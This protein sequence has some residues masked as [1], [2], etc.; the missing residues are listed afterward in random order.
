[1]AEPTRTAPSNDDPADP[2]DHGPIHHVP[3]HAARLVAGITFRD[4]LRR[5]GGW[6]ATLL[7][8]M[9]FAL[10]VGALGMT[11]ERVQ[12]RIEQRSFA[13]AIGGDVEGAQEL[14]RQM[15]SPRLIFR[16]AAD[17]ADEVTRSKASS[18]IVFPTGVDR[19][20][21][22]GQQVELQTFYRAS[23]NISVESF[24][25]V[26]T[27]L[28]EV[29]LRRLAQVNGHDVAV[30]GGPAVEVIELPRDERINRIQL[31]R[32]LAP[33]AALLCIGVVTSVASVFGAARERRSIEP[34]LV[35]P[36][37]RRDLALGIALGSY[38]LACLQV[39]AAVVL[40][41]LTAALPASTNHQ[42][43]AT[44]A[45]MLVA[46]VLASLLL[47]SVGTAL[48]CV[49]G[50]L[51]T[52]GDDAVSLGDLVS[53]VFVAAGVLVFVAPTVGEAPLLN[54]VPV[55]GQVLVMRDLV[56]GT[57]RPLGVVLAVLSAAAVF[58]L[59]VRFAGHCLE[60][61]KRLARAIR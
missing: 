26:G 46:G 24:N 16:P 22:A 47:A 11:G 12:D 39:L 40:L 27:R 49:A 38:P 4:L 5:P 18:G 8:G 53:V 45:V 61:E 2:T 32:Q 14:L 48:G 55:L 7:T 30:G 35:L 60:D 52:G 37:R 43:P 19:S 36:L 29:E 13:V 54:A 6:V 21:A 58:A 1:M 25:T 56:G 42:P 33:I 31:A 3:V 28:Q 59:S 57:A 17:V 10:L 23:Q 20:L 50:S 44:L 41:V 34:L 9:L 51:G 15:A